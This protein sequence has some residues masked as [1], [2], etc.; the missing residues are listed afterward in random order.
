MRLSRF[1]VWGIWVPFFILILGSVL[2]RLYPWDM[3][4]ADEMHSPET[5]WSKGKVGVWRF[6]Y[7]YGVIPAVSVTL[8]A[9]I[10]FMLGLGHPLR[11]WRKLSLYLMSCMAIG[12]G[13]ITNGLLKEYWG[14]PRPKQIQEFGGEFAFEPLL[15]IDPESIGKSFPCGHATMGFFFFAFV[16]F[17]RQPATRL[18]WFLLASLYGGLIGYARLTQGGHFPSDTLWA[19]GV[20][21]FTSLGFYYL[22]GLQKERFLTSVVL[23]KRP[24][25]MLPAMGGGIFSILLLVSLATP[26]EKIVQFKLEEGGRVYQKISL[27]GVSSFTRVPHEQEHILF[28][29]EGYGHRMPKSRHRL[30][31]EKEGSLLHLTLYK[32]GFFTELN[33]RNTLYYPREIEVISCD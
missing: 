3:E 32:T 16:F 8:G 4:W 20:S 18:L 9:F 6:L 21:W 7:D 10:L 33:L 28:V 13:L 14:R 25:W 22:Y 29:S 2:F 27:S 5:G 23:Q 30:K 19:A 17:V 12:P 26:Y 1:N 31:M 11:K 15:T 24:W